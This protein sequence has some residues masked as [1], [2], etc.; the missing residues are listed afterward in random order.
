M[1]YPVAIALCKD[2]HIY[3]YCTDLC[4]RAQNT[5]DNSKELGLIIVLLQ[6]L[7]EHFIQIY[8][9]KLLVVKTVQM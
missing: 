5:R 6:M 9:A 4:V 7:Y 3:S 8:V 2:M 1:A